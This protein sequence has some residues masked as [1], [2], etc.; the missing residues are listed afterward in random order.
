MTGLPILFLCNNTFFSHLIFHFLLGHDIAQTDHDGALFLSILEHV[1][2][3]LSAEYHVV[4]GSCGLTLR[5]RT[6]VY[7]AGFNSNLI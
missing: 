4:L 3:I 1:C 5:Q 6:V 2:K 7:F